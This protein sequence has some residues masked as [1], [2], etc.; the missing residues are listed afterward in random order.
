MA[1]CTNCGNNIEDGVK[2][3]PNCG[4][5]QSSNDNGPEI[6]FGDVQVN[7]SSGQLNVGQLVWSIINLLTCCTPLGIAGLILTLL[8]KD[9][10]SAEEE[11]SKLKTAKIC[12]LI[13]T[14]GAG[15]IILLYIALV[16]VGVSA[17]IMGY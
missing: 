12:N 6:S 16:A 7:K 1:Y 17:G 11:T 14:I 10:H 3:C 15:V 4:A 8:A 2:F 13:G 9:A 5:Q